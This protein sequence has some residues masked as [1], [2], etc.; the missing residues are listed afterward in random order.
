MTTNSL[1]ILGSSSGQPQANRACA[2]YML[3]VDGR[4][5]LIDCGGGVTSSLLRCGFDPRKIE[6][7]FISHSHS[8][9][10]GELSLFIQMFYVMKRSTPLTVLLPGEFVGPFED[11]LRAVYMFREKFPFELEIT[12]YSDGFV[13]DDDFKLTAIANSHN[14][15]A[16]ELIARLGLQNKGQS[17]SFKIE[18][19]NKSLLYSAD[20]GSFDDIRDHLNNLDY[21]IVESTHVD[22][23]EVIAHARD[24]TVSKYII[25]H[26]GNEQEV[27]ALRHLITDSQC[28]N[29]QLAEDGMRLEL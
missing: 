28:T 20:I 12:G 29:I 5:N 6:R 8:D 15:S 10:V 16:M 7:V 24:S 11:Y 25:T 4:L 9:H 22:A 3:D 19:G 26:L 14:A 23:K 17:H 13:Y 2:G 1:T 18:V 27:D 21:A